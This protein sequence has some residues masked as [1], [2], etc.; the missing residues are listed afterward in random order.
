VNK[1]HPHNDRQARRGCCGQWV[2]CDCDC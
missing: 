1:W 2:C